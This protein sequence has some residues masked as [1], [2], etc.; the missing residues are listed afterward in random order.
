MFTPFRIARGPDRMASVG[1]FRHTVGRKE[2]GDVFYTIEDWNKLEDQHAVHEMKFT[3]LTA[4][5]DNGDKSQELLQK[6]TRQ[7]VSLQL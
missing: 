7:C 3:G 6:V 5:H 2:N 4:F 1:N